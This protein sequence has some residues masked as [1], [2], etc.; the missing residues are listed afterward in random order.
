MWSGKDGC[1]FNRAKQTDGRDVCACACE[2]GKLSEG[3]R[4]M[5]RNERTYK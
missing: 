1:I 2:K 5:M 4:E 3:E